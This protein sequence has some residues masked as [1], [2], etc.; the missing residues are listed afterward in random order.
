MPQEIDRTKAIQMEI[1]EPVADFPIRFTWHKW[2]WPCIFDKQVD[3]IRSD[4]KRARA[5]GKLIV[6]LSCPISGRGG[7]DQSTNVEIAKGVE[8]RLLSQWGERFWVL[9]PAQYQLES[10]EGTGLMEKHAAECDYDLAELRQAAPP[11]GGD[12]MRMWTQVLVVDQ[13]VYDFKDPSSREPKLKD[14][15]QHFDAFYF[16]GPKDVYDFFLG[17]SQI[18]LTA[19]IETYFARKFATNADFRA[20]YSIP[21]LAWG[22]D[23][24]S[25]PTRTVAQNRALADL[26][27]RWAE[28][29]RQFVRFYSLRASVNFSLGSH[30]EWEI[31]RQINIRRRQA[32]EVQ[33]GDNLGVP[34]QIAGFFDQSQIDPAAS[35]AIL[36]RGYAR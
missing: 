24:Q 26:K 32:L 20:I 8:R 33:D 5:D 13:G 15:S 31:F 29:R 6:Y 18:T 12:Y 36:S 35:E 17:G 23:G 3:L 28:M 22:A 21:D 14:S 4:I 1:G 27:V 34:E 11:S 9:N 7:G 30:D 25:D 2:Y 19:A 16:L 10:K